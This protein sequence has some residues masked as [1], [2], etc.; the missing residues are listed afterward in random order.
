MVGGQKYSDKVDY[1]GQYSWSQELTAISDV[2]VLPPASDWFSIDGVAGFGWN[3]SKD[4]KNV[5]AKSPPIL[6]L[7]KAYGAKQRVYSI[8]LKRLDVRLS[9]NIVV[10]SSI[11]VLIV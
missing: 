8:L 3:P 7:L 1:I 11:N 6:N 5:T 9:M 10:Y 4:I 2:Y